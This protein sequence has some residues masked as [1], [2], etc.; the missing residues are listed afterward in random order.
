V[1]VWV[2][3]EMK[4][5]LTIGDGNLTYSLSLAKSSSSIS[6]TATTYDSYEA[7]TVKYSGIEETIKKLKD[8][9]HDVMHG[10]NACNLPHFNK[11]FDTVIFMHP[12]VPTNET[13]S[14]ILTNNCL[15][16]GT[17][18][19]N[20]RMLQQFL[21]SVINVVHPEHGEVHI[22]IK[23]VY[24]YSW[25]DVQLMGNEQMRFKEKVKWQEIDGYVSR[26]VERDQNFAL[27]E[28]YTFIFGRG[29]SEDRAVLNDSQRD[30][31]SCSHCHVTCKTSEDFLRHEKSKKHRKRMILENEWDK[32]IS[33]NSC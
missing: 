12:L 5:V 1:C 13:S 27:T 28:S 8:M 18:L 6:I 9:G 29:S 11:T 31:L 21:Q 14:F 26:T 15:Y 33:L 7:L 17:I 32:F 16:Y 4:E 19:I 30:P 22:T 24:P 3:L 23:D 10:I 25:W 2:R 20:R